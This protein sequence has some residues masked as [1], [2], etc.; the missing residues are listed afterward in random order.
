MN[1]TEWPAAP[2]LIDLRTRYIEP[3][4]RYHTWDHA[5]DVM[6]RVQAHAPDNVPML[7]AALYHDAI[8]VV[9]ATDNERNSADLFCDHNVRATW[10]RRRMPDGEH[11]AS[12]V[13][14]YILATAKHGQVEREDC[15][16]DV[17][18]FL[19]CDIA[20]FAE[21]DWAR[22]KATDDAIRDELLTRYGEAEVDAGR[23][24]FLRGMLDKRSIFLSAQFV[25]HEAQ[26]RANI[27]RLLG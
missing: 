4:R 8:Y 26:A 12:K 16:P 14:R 23:R 18:L 21:P 27:E 3:H 7:L 22:F 24:K 15:P 1:L 19:D 11:L 5:N 13:C 25:K 2:A 9:G 6:E 10:F 20:S 17:A